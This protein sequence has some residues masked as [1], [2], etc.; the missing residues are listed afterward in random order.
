MNV[1]LVDGQKQAVEPKTGQAAALA[2]TLSNS[3]A[4][5]IESQS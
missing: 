1:R 3:A 4:G 5:L 2:E